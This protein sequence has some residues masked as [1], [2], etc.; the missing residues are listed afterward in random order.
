MADGIKANKSGPN[1]LRPGNCC[2]NRLKSAVPKAASSAGGMPL[3]GRKLL[4]AVIRA[5]APG[6]LLDFYETRFIYDF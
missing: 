3:F 1:A 5:A 4:F 6:F 2:G